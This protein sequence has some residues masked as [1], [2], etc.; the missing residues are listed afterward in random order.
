MPTPD[1]KAPWLS[2]PGLE[3]QDRKRRR[4]EA[5]DDEDDD[6]GE[7]S[8]GKR[9]RLEDPSKHDDALAGCAESHSLQPAESEA[10]DASGF[11][12]R[13][14][15]APTSVRFGSG[16]TVTYRVLLIRAIG[17]QRSRFRIISLALRRHEITVLAPSGIW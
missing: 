16:R 1:S 9:T 14:A 11:R 10:T 8:L 17:D 12:F 3:R 2:R 5:D 13:G 7:Q 6:G 15:L 4:A